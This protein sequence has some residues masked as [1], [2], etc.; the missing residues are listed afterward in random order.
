MTQTPDKSQ[1]PTPN[2][3]PLHPDYEESPDPI[4][5]A[6]FTKLMD[7][8][9][10]EPDMMRLAR[11]TTVAL[12]TNDPAAPLD[13]PRHPTAR[14]VKLDKSDYRTMTRGTGGGS[15]FLDHDGDV[16]ACWATQ[17]SASKGLMGV[18]VFVNGQQAWIPARAFADIIS[19]LEAFRTGNL[20]DTTPPSWAPGTVH[21]TNDDLENEHDNDNA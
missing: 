15:A 1:P 5:E 10:F 3:K 17:S 19:R 2:N 21:L 12:P 14:H 11:A 9:T 18:T 8:A 13:I 20:N 16:F 6:I 4:I 7:A